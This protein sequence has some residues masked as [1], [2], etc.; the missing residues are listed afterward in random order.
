M[1]QIYETHS[2]VNN[3]CRDRLQLFEIVLSI[4]D[5]TE[6]QTAYSIKLGAVYYSVQ[7]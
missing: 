6:G 7:Y 5:N 3:S 2:V 1:A 4:R